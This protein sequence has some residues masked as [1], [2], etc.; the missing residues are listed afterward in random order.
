MSEVKWIKITTDMFDNRKIKQL[1]SMPEGD[2]LVVVWMKILCLA[3]NVND[4]GN[5]YFTKDLPY[6]ESMLSTEFN[7]P[8]NL[9]TLALKTFER[10]N[11]IEI[12][13][14]FIKVSNWA[15]YQNVEG[16]EELKKR[17]EGDRERKRKQREREKEQR[18]L[19]DKK[20][21]MSRDSHVT[22]CDFS[23]DPSIS[24]SLSNS[25]SLSNSLNNTDIDNL[26][27]ISNLN[28]IGYRKPISNNTIEPEATIEQGMYQ[29]P[30]SIEC[31]SQDSLNNIQE[32]PK[33]KRTQKEPV[34]KDVYFPLDE[35]LNQ[36]FKDFVKMREDIKKPFKTMHAID[37]SMKK[38][39]K[40]SAGDNDKAIEILENSIRNEWQDVYALKDETGKKDKGNIMEKWLNA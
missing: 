13:D 20:G 5:V 38:L 9:I 34:R 3:A 25:N 4:G 8:V 39:E 2:S 40:L 21:K 18:L 32:K 11:M 23:R 35:K 7:K 1:E 19:E 17:K 16:L 24:I 33:K 26:K 31:G 28:P 15:K 37:L 12:V 29:E 27:P 14:N 6:T 22:G 30:T 10:F 36:T